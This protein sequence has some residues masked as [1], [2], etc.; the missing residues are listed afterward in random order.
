MITCDNFVSSDSI[1]HG[2][3][4]RIGGVSGGIY[5]SLNFG[6]GSK[7][8]LAD[9][10]KNIKLAM[11]S[12]DSEVDDL[13]TLYQIHSNK[14]ITHLHR[15]SNKYEADAHVTNVP[16]LVLG[17]KTADCTPVLFVDEKAKVIGAAHAGWKGAISGIIENTILAMQELGADSSNISA[18]IGPT[19]F[20]ESYEVGQEFYQQFI[21][22][23]VNNH[24]FFINSVKANHFMFDLPGFITAKLDKLNL[25]SVSNVNKN[26][27][28]LEDEFYSYRRSCHRAEADYGRNMSIIFL[29]S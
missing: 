14:V 28:I 29:R 20:Q 17:I 8:N 22:A 18:V 5:S 3:F 2:F 10:K 6:E 7:D 11:E 21:N 9:V 1:I 27:Y 13:H 23:D 24:R 19:I 25:L 12:V 4:T 26:T 15:A 16:G